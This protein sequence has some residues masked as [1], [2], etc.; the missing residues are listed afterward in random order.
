MSVRQTVLAR[1]RE[2]SSKAALAV[3]LGLLIPAQYAGPAVDALAAA[4]A[5]WAIATPEGGRVV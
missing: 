3:L 1:L 2:P 5:V 4:L